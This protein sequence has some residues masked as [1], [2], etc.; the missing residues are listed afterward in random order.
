MRLLLLYI[1]NI[2]NI[3]LENDRRIIPNRSIIKNVRTL[4]NTILKY[5]MCLPLHTNIGIYFRLCPL[6]YR[7]YSLRRKFIK[8][9]FCY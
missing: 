7:K 3:T 5:M 2:Y 1:I 8:N 9:N 4:C 6:Q